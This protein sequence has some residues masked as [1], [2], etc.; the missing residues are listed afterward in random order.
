MDLSQTFNNIGQLLVQVLWAAVVLFV[1]WIIAKVVAALVGK[2][3]HWLKI[4]ERLG[5]AAGETKVPQLERILTLAVYYLI[6]LFAVIAA[7]Q[8]LGLTIITQPLNAMLNAIFAYIPSL[9]AGGVV[10]FIAWLVATILRAIVRGFLESTKMEK[11]VGEA[12][13]LKEWPLARAIG[14]VA[15]WLVWLLFLPII[16]AALG[17]EALIAPVMNLLGQLLGWIPNLIVAALIVIVGWFIARIVQRI[18]TSF[19]AALGTD[20]LADRVGLSKYMGKT[21]LSAL[22]GLIVFVLI[23]IPIIIAALE[24]L[25]LT[26]LTAPLVA[27]LTAVMVAIPV[28]IMA[29]L[30]IIVAYF[31]G[32]VVGDFVASFLAGLGFDNILVRLG[33]AKEGPKG[34]R[35]PSQVV[36]WLVMIGIVLAAA[37]SAFTML[38]LDPL[39]QLLSG[40]IVFAWQI[41]LGLLIFGVGLWIA[42]WA[43]NFVIESNWPHKYF[44]A[45]VAR[46]GIIVLSLFMALT[47]MG[48]AD[49][50]ITLAFGVPLLGVALAIGL[51][52]GLG[53]R[54]T[55]AQQLDQWQVS[56]KEVDKQLAAQAPETPAAPD[57]PQA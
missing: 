29:V 3:L 25:N 30:V 41:I 6:L 48:I 16:F 56:M 4:D 20:K 32:R 12:A 11:R 24:A 7:L 14:E 38:R 21:T 36:G 5:K 43:A 39:A 15:Y 9:I 23:M 45:L 52:F 54:E 10:I 1:G 57:Q 51:A 49:S 33:L 34:T 26:A 22:I 18:A 35:T 37:L 42:T 17:L 28:M 8:V 31:V 40:F 47:Q 46:I 44:L 2:L 53:G 55:A 19:F 27:M 13:D 50:I